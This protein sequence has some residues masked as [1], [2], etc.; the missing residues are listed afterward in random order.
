MLEPENGSRS[1]SDY[2]SARW[3]VEACSCPS[4]NIAVRDC[5]DLMGRLLGVDSVRAR[6]LVGQVGAALETMIGNGEIEDV[7]GQLPARNE[8]IFP[9]EPPT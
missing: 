8:D 3:F 9:P 5:G 6:E 2:P 1:A 7:S 4:Q